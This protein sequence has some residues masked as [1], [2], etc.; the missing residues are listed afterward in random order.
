[1]VSR[2]PVLMSTVSRQRSAGTRRFSNA[3]MS[4][5]TRRKAYSHVQRNRRRRVGEA[6]AVELA[7]EP[8]L[9]APPC[10]EAVTGQDGERTDVRE[11]A[12]IRLHGKV[13]HR[14]AIDS[15]SQERSDD[16]AAGDAGY[17]DDL[18]SQVAQR[19]DSADEGG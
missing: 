16:T 7:I 12:I 19:K 14:R 1:M 13:A 2:S 10:G 17:P 6:R 4:V 15:S 3:R 5:H 9:E 11:A 18:R 8:V